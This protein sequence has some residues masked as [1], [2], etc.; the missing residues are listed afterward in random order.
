VVSVA[1]TA[2]LTDATFNLVPSISMLAT[3]ATC[4]TATALV[5]GAG[6]TGGNTASAGAAAPCA[7]GENPELFYAVSVP[8]NS[9]ADVNIVQTAGQSVRA[10][11]LDG[12]MAASC[13]VAAT[14]TMMGANNSLPV[15]NST[16]G[17]RTFIVAISSTAAGAPGQFTIQHRGNAALAA[18]AT[19]A[20]AQ[21]LGAGA[22]AMANTAGGGATPTTCRPTDGPQLFYSI[23]V[24]PATRG[25]LTLTRSG[26]QDVAMRVL[27]SCG[28][29]LCDAS[30]ATAGPMAAST[31]VD[32]GSVARTVIVSVSS[33][34]ATNAANFSLNFATT[35]LPYTLT[36]LS[37]QSCEPGVTMAVA[38][39]NADD[40][41]SAVAALPF[42]VPYFGAMATH[43]SASANG[44][45]QLYPNAMG[46]PF[47]MGPSATNAT[48]PAAA[49]AAPNGVVAAF[50]DDLF[51][52]DA[53]T[54]VTTATVGAMGSR[55]FI[56]QWNNWTHFDM[57]SRSV[58]LTFQT[59]FYEGTGVIEHVY[60][61]MMPGM[62]TANIASGASATIGIESLDGSAAAQA[63]FNT[64]MAVAA[65]TMFR[66]T[67]N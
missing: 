16:A 30:V 51:P 23:T 42:T 26:A 29:M 41:H 52:V 49:M 36:T 38:G 62:D 28:A 40:S 17:T 22:T 35:R 7:T 12:C 56:V 6:A 1:S 58:R 43:F 11:I 46:M 3:N 21:I 54:S 44:F 61:S 50:W 14:T 8:A 59:R 48:L 10:R 20:T 67:P 66:F 15:L 63:S 37:G 55:R 64:P 32:T 39:V 9:R 31:N 34:S 24:P 5:S 60:C 65:G 27:S 45:A 13:P 18:N 53:M 2:Q 57:V 19:C 47:T 33:T 25:T 4:A